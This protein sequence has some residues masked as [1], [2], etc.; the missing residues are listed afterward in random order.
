MT[1]TPLNGGSCYWGSFQA[2]G[3]NAVHGTLKHIVEKKGA[4]EW[5]RRRGRDSM[6]SSTYTAYG[7]PVARKDLSDKPEITV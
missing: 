2:S 6:L 7:A 5:S 1:A 3:A 4:N